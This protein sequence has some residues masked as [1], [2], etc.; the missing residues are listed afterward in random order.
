M[1]RLPASLSL[2]LDDQWTYLKTHGEDSWKDYPSYLNYAVP[3]IL[4]LLDK[5]ELKITFF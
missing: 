5:H 1:A 3:R 2:D 4:D